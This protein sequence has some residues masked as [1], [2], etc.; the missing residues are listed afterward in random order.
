MPSLHFNGLNEKVISGS[1]GFKENI[2]SKTA[3][4]SASEQGNFNKAT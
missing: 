1:F 3:K 2:E 4:N